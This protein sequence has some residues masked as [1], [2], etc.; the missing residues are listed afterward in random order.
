MKRSLEVFR[1][2]PRQDSF[3]DMFEK[4]ATTVDQAAQSLLRLMTDYHDVEETAYKIKTMEH[5]ADEIAHTILKKLNTTFVTPLDREDIHALVS[6][7][8][9]ILDY[10][11]NAA[12]RMALYEIAEPTEEAIKLVSIL[13]EASALVTKAIFRLRDI[14]HPSVIREAC[15]EINRLENQGDQVNRMAI[16]K[17]FQMHDNPI[18]ALKWREI[19]D[20][21]ETAIDKCEDVADILESTVLKNG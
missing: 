9:D 6:A 1:L 4:Q 13:A 11:E 17:L 18:E 5:D 3:F 7:M 14:K 2:L 15:V 12:D 21:I 16:A 10:I 19:F 8:D 20:H